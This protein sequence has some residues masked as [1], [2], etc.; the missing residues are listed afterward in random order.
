MKIPNPNIL[1]SK[2]EFPL[3]DQETKLSSFIDNSI[4]IHKLSSFKPIPC[5]VIYTIMVLKTPS[6]N[7][8]AQFHW[9]INQHFS[10]PSLTTPFLFLHAFLIILIHINTH[11][12]FKYS[13]KTPF[14]FLHQWLAT[15]LVRSYK[16]SFKITCYFNHF[17]VTN[18]NSIQFLISLK[19]HHEP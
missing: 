18:I 7:L 5:H 4:N 17:Y 12:Q 9:L 16:V 6:K 8:F 13:N 14:F 19:I 1:I 15:H 3:E 2:L 11:H 10:Q